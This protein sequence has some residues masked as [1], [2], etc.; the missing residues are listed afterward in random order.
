MRGVFAH[1]PYRY[2]KRYP[3]VGNIELP[4]GVMWANGVTPT[5]EGNTLYEL[6]IVKTHIGETDYFKAVLTPFK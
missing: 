2:R 4:S 6:S 3:A 5:L 1:S